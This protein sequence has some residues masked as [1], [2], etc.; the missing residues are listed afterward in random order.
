VALGALAYLNT[1]GGSFVWDDHHLIVHNT[2]VRQSSPLPALL[3]DF[4]QEGE[5]T[6]FYRPLVSLTYFLEFRLWRLAPAG[7]HAANVVYHLGATL[8]VVWVAWLLFRRP[9]PAGIAGI[10]FALHPIHT[11]SV[12]FISGRP[13]LLAGAFSAAAL[14]LYIRRQR[15][16]GRAS[17]PSVALFAAGLLSKETALALPAVLLVHAVTLGR[18]DGATAARRRAVLARLAPY[19]IVATLYFGLRGVVLGSPVG[20]G[21]DGTGPGRRLL[22][23][24]N[25]VGEYV[26]LLIVPFPATPDRLADGT[27]SGSTV[28]AIALLVVIAGAALGSARWSPVPSFLLGWFLLTLLPA[29]PL[30]PGRPP[31]VA[32][33]FLYIPS[34]AWAWFTGWLGAAVWQ[35]PWSRPR[36]LR[37]A[38]VMAAG[39]AVVGSIALTML[40]NL[41][42]RD[43]GR[44]FT[45]M[46]A[47]EPRSYLAPLNLGHLNL[48][49]GDPDD[50]EV[51]LRRALSRR[52]DSAPALLALAVVESRRGAHDLAIRY[53]E[54]ARS[55]DPDAEVV[56]TQLGAI[57]GVAGRYAEAAQSSR[58]AIRRNPRRIHP[59]ANLVA[60]LAD[61]GR[62]G[63]AAAELAEAER[64]F[65]GQTYADAVDVR[66]LH[67]LRQRLA[68]G[69]KLR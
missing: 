65:A 59:R 66:K 54:R 55:L 27:V 48:F 40:R 61:D 49:T 24:I 45:R 44:L 2:L 63:E 23:T 6:G 51:H 1:L 41:D 58:E 21:A 69:W 26:R 53:G 60:A 38:M 50:A 22:A 39:L 46:L 3:S 18:D 31:Q 13:D 28:V 9:L 15:M 8:A 20:S 11:E 68:A 10:V 47:S 19:V 4:W 35:A 67:H 36:W 42:W 5:R 43:E 14:A 17:I 64:I 7:Y 12:A 62:L 52:P 25:A 29:T 56:H 37:A 33:R 57:Y 34:A 30:V 32:E 16:D